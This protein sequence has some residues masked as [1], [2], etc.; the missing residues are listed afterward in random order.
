MYKGFN[1]TLASWSGNRVMSQQCGQ[2]WLQTFAKANSMYNTSNQLGALQLVTWD[3]YEEGTEIESGIDNCLSVSSSM[4]NTTLQWA[5]TGDESTVDHYT[6]FISL[7]GQNLMPMGDFPVGTRQVD[8]RSYSPAVGGTYTLY[9]KGVGKP[10]IRNVMSGPASLSYTAGLH[11]SPGNGTTVATP[12]AVNAYA[13]SAKPI[14]AMV[15]YVDNN[16]VYRTYSGSLSTNLPLSGGNHLLVINAWDSSGALMQSKANITV[17]ALQPAASLAVSTTSAVAPATITAS[18]GASTD[19][20]SGGSITASTINWG[21]GTS[22]AGPNSAHTYASPGVYTVTGTVTD[23]YGMSATATAS[24][25][26]VGVS[27]AQPAQGATV[28]SPLVISATAYDTNRIAAMKVYVDNVAVL[29]SSTNTAN[30]SVNL[31][32]GAHRIVVNAW[33]DVTGVLYQSSV[34]VNVQ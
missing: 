23:N 33:E 7:D 25:T 18:T 28:Q 12:V 29:V 9:V 24:V 13:A 22:S 17:T 30:T 19:P 34:T 20:N 16:E 27:I 26:A 1:D 4:A 5:V 32:R 21:D 31:K 15:A 8:L 10:S 14:S 3:D 2:T 11:M 6:V